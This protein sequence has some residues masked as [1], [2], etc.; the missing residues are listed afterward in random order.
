[1]V[2]GLQGW[3]CGEPRPTSQTDRSPALA[4]EGRASVAGG[5]VGPLPVPLPLQDSPCSY[6]TGRPLMEPVCFLS[7]MEQ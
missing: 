5:E 6:H 4:G 1:M 2:S 7:E 3:L